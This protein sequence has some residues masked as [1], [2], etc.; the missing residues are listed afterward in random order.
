MDICEYLHET[1]FKVIKG[2]TPQIKIARHLRKK[3]FKPTVQYAECGRYLDHSYLT[4]GE[5][6][7]ELHDDNQFFLWKD[8]TEPLI[9]INISSKNFKTTNSLITRYCKMCGI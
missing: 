3:G 5:L 2:D 8:I 4:N 6:F 1:G 7:A 9:N